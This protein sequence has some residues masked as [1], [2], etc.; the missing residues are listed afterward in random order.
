MTR[1][2]KKR[3]GERGSSGAETRGA[4][5]AEWPGGEEGTRMRV[6]RRGEEEKR[7]GG[8]RWRRENARKSVMSEN[9]KVTIEHIYV[10]MTAKQEFPYQRDARKKFFPSAAR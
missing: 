3:D 9:F 8:A 6:A 1:V 10:I 5:N 7:R 4:D 2:A